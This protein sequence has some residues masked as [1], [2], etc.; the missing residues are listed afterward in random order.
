MANSSRVVAA[1]QAALAGLL[2]TAPAWAQPTS[3]PPPAAY[4]AAQ[5]AASSNWP[6]TLTKEG[7]SITVYQPQAI[8]W[9]DRQTLTARAAIAITQP[10]HDQTILGNRGFARH[11]HERREGG[12]QPLGPQA[13]EHPFPRTRHAT[14][15]GVA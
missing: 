15:N 7:A 8:S 4:L 14:G 11:Q 9:P 1:C 5:A 10:E 12:D 3:P 6:H 13:A 2:L